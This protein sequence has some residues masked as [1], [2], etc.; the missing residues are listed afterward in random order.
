MPYEIVHFPSGKLTLEL[1]LPKGKWDLPKQ[2]L[3]PRSVDGMKSDMASNGYGP[4]L[5]RE[6]LDF[7]YAI[8]ARARFDAD[9]PLY[10]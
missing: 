4:T 2:F 5:Y 8:S 1:F 6:G 9:R 10:Q 7:F 3:A